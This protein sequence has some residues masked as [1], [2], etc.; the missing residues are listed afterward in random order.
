MGRKGRRLP[1]YNA[2]Q[3]GRLR[4]EDKQEQALSKFGYML[5]RRISDGRQT[6]VAYNP[7]YNKLLF[8]QNGTDTKSAKDIIT[9]IEL[10]GGRLKQTQRYAEVKQAY[11]EAKDKYKGAKFIDVGY[12][13]G[14]ALVN[15]VAKPEDR[16]ITYNAG[17]IPG[18]KVREHVENIHVKGDWISSQ[19]PPETT[20]LIAPVENVKETNPFLKLH[21]VEHLKNQPL[22][23]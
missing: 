18:Q 21:S 11:A 15:Y 12:S 16:A 14:G 10:V 13:L 4:N 6:V 22:F 17:F 1:L 19:Y 20:R 23:V 3:I 7:K 5:D 2:I 8:L 9:D